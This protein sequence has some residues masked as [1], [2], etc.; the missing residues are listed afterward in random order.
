MIEE[1]VRTLAAGS[2]LA[3][4]LDAI[5]AQWAGMS[6]RERTRH[7]SAREFAHRLWRTPQTR[8]FAWQRG[9]RGLAEIA[10]PEAV[11]VVYKPGRDPVA[12]SWNLI[13]FDPPTRSAFV[14]ELAS[15]T[16]VAAG[17]RRPAQRMH[18]AQILAAFQIEEIFFR[19]Q[20]E[21]LSS[22][23]EASTCRV[24]EVTGLD[25]STAG[26]RSRLD[27]LT[28]AL[29]L[30]GD[31][32]ATTDLPAGA[33]GD[34]ARVGEFF[35]NAPHGTALAIAP[36]LAAECALYRAAGVLPDELARFE[37]A[38]ERMR[39]VLAGRGVSAPRAT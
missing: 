10:G 34:D 16:A 7:G 11:Q 39:E 37:L 17:E 15:V 32:T 6:A 19:R 20:A 5:I 30:L 27:E 2:D 4:D 18:R 36:A 29:F 13:G 12:R 33:D 21:Q 22:F 25:G 24:I 26:R 1:Q 8:A 23:L 3:P 9:S 28:S 38:L 14:N 31:R 35:V